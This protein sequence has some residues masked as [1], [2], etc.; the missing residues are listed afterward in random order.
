MGRPKALATE[1]DVQLR[2]QKL[3]A[4]KVHLNSLQ[5]ALQNAVLADF[6]IHKRPA[7][8]IRTIEKRFYKALLA[9]KV[10][11]AREKARARKLAPA[12]VFSSGNG[13]ASSLSAASTSSTASAN[14]QAHIDDDLMLIQ[15]VVD[16]K[17]DSIEMKQR[18]KRDIHAAEVLARNAV[19]LNDSLWRNIACY[20]RKDSMLA[21]H[22]AIPFTNIW[23]V[24][25]FYSEKKKSDQVVREVEKSL[26][27]T[28]S[29]LSRY[30]KVFLSSS[31]FS[32]FYY[33]VLIFSFIRL[34]HI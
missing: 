30:I 2:R 32:F 23:E 21:L 19:L 11:R 22:K 8:G 17:L 28:I 6:L 20:L 5:P 25:W 10:I 27:C 14:V 13:I 33:Y 31:F 34:S 3:A 15:M 9:G 29:G 7:M 12:V 4:K 16:D 18:F 26:G 24:N 1:S